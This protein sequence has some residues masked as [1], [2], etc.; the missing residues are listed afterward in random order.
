VTPARRRHAVTCAAALLAV[1]LFAAAAPAQDKKALTESFQQLDADKDGVLTRKE[2]PGS[3]GQFAAIDRDKDGKLTLAEFLASDV[4]KGM[5]AANGRN[6]KEPHPRT[7]LTALAPARLRMAQQLDKNKDG[8]V[9][10]SEWTGTDQAFQQLD[11]DGNGVLDK[12]DMAIAEALAPAVEPPLPLSKGDPPSAD[13]LLKKLDT[14]GDGKLSQDEAGR[15]KYLAEVFARADQN[16]DKVLDLKELKDLVAAVKKLRDEQSRATMRPKAYQ[17]PFDEWDK[18]KDG[19]LQANEFLAG[20]ALFDRIDLDRDGTITKDELARYVKSVEGEDFIARF[21][22][23]GDGR[24]TLAEFG[25]P[26]EV[27]RRLDR[28]GDGVVTR[29]EL[30]SAERK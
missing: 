30:S 10:R 13:D 21:D 26:A 17:V 14:D 18:N 9:S 23:D 24:V 2:F 25:G 19:K 27:F 11:L 15:N 8:K 16:H 22:Q 1:T 5:L 3:D 29:A 20:R 7:E 12:K 4:A 6:L 28:N